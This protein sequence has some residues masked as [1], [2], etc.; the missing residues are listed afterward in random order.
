MNF[1]ENSD[2]L[3]DIGEFLREDIGRGDITTQS[4]VSEDVRGIGRFLAK[5]KLV[6]LRSGSRRSRLR[7]S[8]P[9]NA[10]TRNQL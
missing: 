5:E 8:R 10:R 6:N 2:I 3:G 4:I 7:A 9:G 1:L